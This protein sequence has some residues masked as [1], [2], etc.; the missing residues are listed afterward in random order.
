MVQSDREHGQRFSRTHR[1][2]GAPLRFRICLLKSN[3]RRRPYGVIYNGERGVV[4]VKAAAKHAFFPVCTLIQKCDRH[5]RAAVPGP[6]HRTD[7]TNRATNRP[8]VGPA[9]VACIVATHRVRTSSMLGV[10]AHG[11]ESSCIRSESSR[12]SEGEIYSLGPPAKATAKAQLP[13]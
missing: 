3:R 5:W 6:A 10:A 8:H 12:P 1:S 7:G 2:S 11:G 9:G 4:A 13:G